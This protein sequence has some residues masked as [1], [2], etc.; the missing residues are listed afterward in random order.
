MTTM[1]Q[2]Q[3][4]EWWLEIISAIFWKFSWQKSWDSIRISLLLLLLL[5]LYSSF[6]FATFPQLHYILIYSAGISPL[7][8]SCFVFELHIHTKWNWKI[9]MWLVVAIRIICTRV[10]V[11]LLFHSAWYGERALIVV[12]H[13][14]LMA[15]KM[16]WIGNSVFFCSLCFYWFEFLFT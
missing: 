3:Q 1:T 8:H 2:C 15:Q 5:F 13:Y 9:M 7:G 14:C 10:F 11:I 4:N 16:W 12:C 6:S